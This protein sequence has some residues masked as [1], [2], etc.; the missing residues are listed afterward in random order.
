[1]LPPN[2]SVVSF[3]THGCGAAVLVGPETTFTILWARHVGSVEAIQ[4][5]ADPAAGVPAAMLVPARFVL[6]HTG[7]SGDGFLAGVAFAA[8]FVCHCHGAN[9]HDITTG[10]K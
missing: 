7:P 8:E 6:Y 5:P 10:V 9:L 1:M 4:A 2:P 3:A